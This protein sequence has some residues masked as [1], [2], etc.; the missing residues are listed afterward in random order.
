MVGDWVAAAVKGRS[1]EGAWGFSPSRPGGIVASD[2]GLRRYSRL[3]N[4]S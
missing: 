3:A 2:I 1:A 4:I